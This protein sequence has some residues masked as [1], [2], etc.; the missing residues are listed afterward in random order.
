M[1]FERV[2]ELPK[3]VNKTGFRKGD[4]YEQLKTVVELG[5]KYTKVTALPG[6]YSN[7]RY[8]HAIIINTIDRY[9]EF[10][11][12]FRVELRNGDTYLIRTDLE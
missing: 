11:S 12:I 8:V 9:E 5:Y 4:I 6:E 2:D 10:K 1:H 3:R 7:D